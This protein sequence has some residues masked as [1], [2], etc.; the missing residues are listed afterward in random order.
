MFH[1]GMNVS[2]LPAE[3]LRV[4]PDQ[5]VQEFTQKLDRVPGAPQ[6]DRHI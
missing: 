4:Q 5:E 2:L 1:Q 6:C 3:L